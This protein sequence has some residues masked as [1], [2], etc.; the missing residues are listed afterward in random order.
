M[1]LSVRDAAR[2]LNVSDKT[3]YRWIKQGRLPAY[4]INDQIRFNRTELLEWAM[5]VKINV[6]VDI[7]EGEG[8][9]NVALTGL[10]DAM[11][12]GGIFYR[13]EGGDVGSVLQSVVNLMPLP[14][15]ADRDFLLQVLLAR[16][17]LGSTGIGNGISIP[18]ARNPIVL[19]VDSPMINLCFLESPVDFNA[20]DG[21]PVHTLFV[22]VSPV[23]RAH[24]HLISRVSYALKQPEFMA[25]IENRKGREAIF[26]AA[27]DI[28][29]ALA[30]SGAGTGNR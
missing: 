29:R 25:V 4:K 16:E 3:V 10:H 20:I 9:Q 13:V 24:L 22:M 12:A 19:H 6:A 14:E 27:A 15:G 28:D 8:E 11:R 26:A 2:I 18:H 17:S 23:L 30:A 21:K 5:R 7:F 1:Q